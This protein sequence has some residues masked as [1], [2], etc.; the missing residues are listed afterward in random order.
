MI[1]IQIIIKSAE[2]PQGHISIIPKKLQEKER[3][4]SIEV[5]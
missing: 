3:N 1:S 2:Y 5:D 4:C